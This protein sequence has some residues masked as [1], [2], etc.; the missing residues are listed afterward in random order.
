[1]KKILLLETA[2]S[3]YGIKRGGSYIQANYYRNLLHKKG[4]LSKIHV[5]FTNKNNIARLLRIIS[6]VRKADYILGFGTPLLNVYV[7]WLCFILRKKGTFIA[8][9]LWFI[10]VIFAV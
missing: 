8:A 4:Y 1:M 10:I 7:Q 2:V 3:F 5:G 6:E 9:I